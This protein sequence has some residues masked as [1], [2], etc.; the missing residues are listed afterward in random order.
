MKIATVVGARPQFIKAAAISRRLRAGAHPGLGEVIIHTGQ[1]YD[2]NMSA[3]FFTELGIPEPALNLGVGSG[4]QAEQTGRIMAALER[5]LADVA[6]DLVLVYGDTNSTLAG[7]LVAAKA[8]LPLAHVEA[9]LRSFRPGMA[10]EVNR[11]VTDRLA[12]MLFCPTEAARMNLAAEGRADA[13][14][15]VGDVMFDVFRHSAADL[16]ADAILGEYG[17]ATRKYALATIHRAENT[18]D[19]ARLEVVLR[20][21]DQIGATL[22]LI[23]PLHPRTRAAMARWRLAPKRLRIVEPQ[24]YRRML[25][26]LTRS[27]ALLTDSGGMQKEAYFAA[28]PCVTLRDETEWVETVAAGWNRLAPPSLGADAIVSSALCAIGNRPAAAPAPI[29]GDGDA[30]GR[31]LDIIAARV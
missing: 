31:I 3:S 23:L 28:V 15:V 17:L 18:D 12:D 2:D 14:H 24:P 10:E 30:A 4:T 9:G 5:A 13:A 21:L 19:P 20:A 8:A 27:A 25:A 1:H 29:Y 6:P 22:P 16:P 26:L 11:V 7:A